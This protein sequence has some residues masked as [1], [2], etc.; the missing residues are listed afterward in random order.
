MDY[1]VVS[2]ME[3]LALDL[4]DGCALLVAYD[5]LLSYGP[6]TLFNVEFHDQ[7]PPCNCSNSFQTRRKCSAVK[8]LK[9]PICSALISGIKFSCFCAYCPC[10]TKTVVSFCPSRALLSARIC[11]LS[12]ITPSEYIFQ[13]LREVHE[14]LPALRRALDLN[15]CELHRTACLV[16]AERITC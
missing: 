14:Q 3:K 16:T 9:S 13:L 11:G 10:L 8:P 6:G 7:V 2:N 1:Q 12:S 5:K 15:A 4:E